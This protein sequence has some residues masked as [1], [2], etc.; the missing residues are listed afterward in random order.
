MKEEMDG[1]STALVKVWQKVRQEHPEL[2]EIK[3]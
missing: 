1:T 2:F 3:K